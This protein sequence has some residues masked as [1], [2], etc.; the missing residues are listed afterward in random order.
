MLTFLVRR[1]ISIFIMLLVVSFAAYWLFYN[2]PGGPLQMIA[3]MQQSGRNKLDAGAVDRI[4]LRYD[5]DLYHGVRYMRWLTGFPNGPIEIGGQVMFSGSPIGCLK[6]APAGQ[7]VI[8]EYADGTRVESNCLKPTYLQDLTNPN[9]RVSKG[10]LR[11]DFGVSQ[12]IARER[13]VLELIETRL[14][15]TL[16]LMGVANLLAIVIAVPIGVLSAV[17]QYSRFDYLVTTITFFGSAMP[18]LFLGIMGILFFSLFL[19]DAGL[20]FLPPQLAESNRDATV[21]LLGEI[22]AGSIGDRI[23]HLVLPVS[24]LTFVSLTGWSRFVRSSMLEVL[25]QDYVR[26]ARA[27]GV[28]ETMVIM[29]HAFRNSMIP[30]VTLLVGV[31]PSLFAGAIVTESIFSWPGLG[32]LYVQALGGDYTVAMAILLISTFLTLLSFLLADV[33]YTVVDPRIRLS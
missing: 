29:K 4:K 9:R 26:T 33:L 5:L 22:L 8:L 18:T 30:F 12:L 20:P 11:L 6:E 15:P 13:P 10:A 21:P 25:K 19:R 2:A 14:A 1:A 24:V 31:L 17:K 7:K 3:E 23:W 32:R 27:K 16:L 28:R